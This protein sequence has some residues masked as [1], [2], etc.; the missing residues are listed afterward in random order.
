MKTRVLLGEQARGFVGALAPAPRRRV[1]AAIKALGQDKGDV[2]QLEGDLAPYWRL[3]VGKIR[4]IFEEQY[5]DGER[6]L[7]CFFADY[8]ATV[9]S[10]LAEL[11]ANNLLGELGQ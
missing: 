7:K 5:Q 11:I 3:R 9:Y 1:W 8:R 10:A 6:L 4:I 2:V